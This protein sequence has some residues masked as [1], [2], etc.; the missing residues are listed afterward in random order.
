MNAV[1]FYQKLGFRVARSLDIKLPPPGSDNPTV[2]YEE[3]CMVW[4]ATGDGTGQDG[5]STR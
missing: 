2:L 5:Q 4:K 1:S 3:R